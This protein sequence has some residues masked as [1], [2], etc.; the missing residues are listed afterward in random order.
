METNN[1]TQPILVQT[2]EEIAKLPK[3]TRIQYTCKNCGKTTIK[4]LYNKKAYK[5][6]EK[7]LCKVCLSEETCRNKYG[8]RNA[9]LCS[10]KVEKLKQN[11]LEKYGTTCTLNT[12]E[13][14]KK[15]KETW[16]KNFGTTNPYQKKEVRD[17]V[18]QNNLRKYG[19][20]CTLSL[21]QTQQKSYN[22]KL[23]NGTLWINKRRYYYD[24]LH[25]D[26]SWEVYFYI[27]YK[28]HGFTIERNKCSFNYVFNN[29][30]HHTVVDFLVNNCFLFEIKAPYLLYYNDREIARNS[31]LMYEENVIFITN[32]KPYKKYVDEKYGKNYLKQFKI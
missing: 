9:M 10:E 24:D 21:K 5:N 8:V 15:K 20:E 2:A 22:S 18:K 16:I 1:D 3:R 27:W 7:L 23:K 17:K 31:M 32:I 30:T 4:L 28:E 6:A 12:E 14:I 11:N 29:K 19:V 13:N 26:S 25:F